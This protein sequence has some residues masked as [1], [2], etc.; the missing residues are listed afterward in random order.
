[1]YMCPLISPEIHDFPNSP[2]N[3][4]L[5]VILRH[6]NNYMESP[7][8]S[9][10]VTPEEDAELTL[11][12]QEE[13]KA[14]KP[15]RLRLPLPYCRERN[16]SKRGGNATKRKP[17][18]RDFDQL[19]HS[20]AFLH[21]PRKLW[22]TT[23]HAKYEELLLS[24]TYE[25]IKEFWFQKVLRIRMKHA[26]S[27]EEAWEEKLRNEKEKMLMEYLNKKFR[28]YIARHKKKNTIIH[29]HPKVRL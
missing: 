19:L 14:T 23:Q 29:I 20:H 2:L 13:V 1:M 16:P 25:G 6:Y 17:E 24:S 9:M 26:K 10:L 7:N 5:I 4:V 22:S 15:E 18:T 28:D 11:I 8:S 3:S 21:K 12:M 27:I